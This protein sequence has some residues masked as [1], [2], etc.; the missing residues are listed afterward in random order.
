MKPRVVI[1]VALVCLLAVAT[2]VSPAW[3]RMT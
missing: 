2:S 1:L 3:M